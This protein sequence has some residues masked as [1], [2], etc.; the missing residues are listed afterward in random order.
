MTKQASND[1]FS[2]A[3]NE[4]TTLNGTA[5]PRGS[6]GYSYLT[7]MSSPTSVDFLPRRLESIAVSPVRKKKRIKIA[8]PAPS[9]PSYPVVANLRD[10]PSELMGEVLAFLA[11]NIDHPVHSECS[12]V[13]LSRAPKF[14]RELAL[15][16]QLWYRVCKRRWKTKVGFTTRMANAEAEA[17]KDTDNAFIKGGYWYRK[18]FAEERD[19]A[20]TT[21]TQE[22]LHSATFSFKLWFQTNR[23]PDMRRAKNALAS[24]LDFR[25][26]S[27][28]MRFD[29]S[30]GRLTGM[31]EQYDVTSAFFMCEVDNCITHINLG[32][33]IERGTS[34]L[35]TLYVF[36]RKD[37]GWELRSQLY[38]IRSVQ[39][40]EGSKLWEDY[41]SKLVIQKRRK[42]TPCKRGRAKYKRREVPDI[43]EVKDFLMW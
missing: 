26:L 12:L 8:A 21:I 29:P 40:V 20:R 7:T 13:G 5:P 14:F 9:E 36:R 19:A 16:D 2:A 23:H 3:A 34:P 38:V 32:I 4:R 28:T 15:N 22:E 1:A 11:P 41:S 37:W 35:S 27:D 30:R 31:P 24:G 10:L 17:T 18:F 42:G 6:G 33:P 39:V 43:E 25:S